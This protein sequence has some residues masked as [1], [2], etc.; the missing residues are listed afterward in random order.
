MAEKE[1]FDPTQQDFSMLDLIQK[2]RG[3]Q[4]NESTKEVY[5]TSS[6]TP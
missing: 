6:V 5:G 3:E 1:T 2:D 4:F